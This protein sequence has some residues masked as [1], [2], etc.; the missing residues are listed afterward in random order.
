VPA[1]V[2]DT[3]WTVAN[4]RRVSNRPCFGGGDCGPSR[5]MSA[6][7][8]ERPPPFSYLLSLILACNG[9]AHPRIIG[10]ARLKRESDL[11][12]SSSTDG[13]LF[14]TNR[15]LPESRQG[16]ISVW[17]GAVVVVS[18]ARPPFSL[19][20]RLDVRYRR[21]KMAASAGA[22]VSERRPVK[23]GGARDLQERK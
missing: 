14:F 23:R 22:V 2:A 17:L 7:S 12:V 9:Y 3:G 6:T 4:L 16:T 19:R 5:I 20:R 15:L 18:E 13:S 8:R 11:S 1:L 21:A 10:G